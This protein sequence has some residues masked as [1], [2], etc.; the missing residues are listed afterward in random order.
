MATHQPTHGTSLLTKVRRRATLHA[1]RKVRSVLDGEYGS[2]HKGRSMDFDDLREYVAGDDV[3]DIDW[4]ATARH[5]QPLIKRYVATRQHGILLVADTGRGMAGLSDAAS[6]KRDVAVMAAGM[7]GQLVLRHGDLVGAVVG[8]VHRDDPARPASGPPVRQLPLGRG[9][10]HLERILRLVHDSVDPDG[11]PS[12]FGD[13]LDVVARTVRRR[14][15]LVLLA[16]EGEL[17]PEHEPQL[18][19]LHA[20]HEILVCHI[21]D[22]SVTDATADVDDLRL[23]ETGSRV[24]TY[25][26]RHARLQAELAEAGRRREREAVSALNRLG[27]VS[28]RLNGEASV[29]RSVYG[30]L[31]RQRARR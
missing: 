14:M 23:V 27:I 10:A 13:L 28:A 31:E 15:I 4:K 16:G 3:K 20:Q 12:R 1:H 25:L 5:G 2:V 7:I 18:K 30:L 8:P 17:G 11:E 19:R 24:P 6:T 9:E 22:A 26:R 21:G 29:P